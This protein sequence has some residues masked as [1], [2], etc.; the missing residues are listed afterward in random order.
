MKVIAKPEFKMF[1]AE[2]GYTPT[3]WAG[4][5][6]M[7]HVT[8]RALANGSRVLPRTAKKVCDYFGIRMMDYFSVVD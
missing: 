8:F 3:K 4:I 7:S 1:L 2:K 5:I 6:G